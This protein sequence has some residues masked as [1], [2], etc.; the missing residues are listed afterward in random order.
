MPEKAKGIANMIG[1]GI[2][3]VLAIVIV[4]KDIVGLIV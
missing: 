4:I 2:L 3:I 1:F